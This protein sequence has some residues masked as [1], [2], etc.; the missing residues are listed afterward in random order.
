MELFHSGKTLYINMDEVGKNSKI[1]FCF[2]LTASKNKA[3]RHFKY[4]ATHVLERRRNKS[5]V[6]GQNSML[7]FALDN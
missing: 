1:D 5:R 6:Y 3:I 4:I 7:K 2:A